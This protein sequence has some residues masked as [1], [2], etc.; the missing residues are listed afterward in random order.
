MPSAM[1]AELAERLSDVASTQEPFDYWLE[2]DCEQ[3]VEKDL[4]HPIAMVLQC[5]G[6]TVEQFEQ[7]RQQLED[8]MRRRYEQ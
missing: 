3:C 2:S 5:K 6:S 4:A 7:A 8:A 1:P